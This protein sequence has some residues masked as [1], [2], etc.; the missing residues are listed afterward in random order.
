MA[1]MIDIS[2]ADHEDAQNA[3]AQPA[4]DGAVRA[5]EVPRESIRSQE[6]N[7]KVRMRPRCRPAVVIAVALCGAPWV[8][9]TLRALH[10]L[11]CVRD[12]AV[13]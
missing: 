3:E 6:T 5:A 7:R 11:A 2:G 4:L 1:C 12:L 13:H 10:V 9:R 8:Y